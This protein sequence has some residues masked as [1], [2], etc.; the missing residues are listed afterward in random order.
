MLKTFTDNTDRLDRYGFDDDFGYD[1]EDDWRE[2]D[3][4]WYDSLKP[5]HRVRSID[6]MYLSSYFEALADCYEYEAQY[7]SDGKHRGYWRAQT[8]SENYYSVYLDRLKKGVEPTESLL[9]K[10]HAYMDYRF[11]D[12]CLS[13]GNWWER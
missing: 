9:G 11:D 1:E 4:I 12:D 3:L 5:Q 8:E 7:D 6:P 13:D 2:H 10:L